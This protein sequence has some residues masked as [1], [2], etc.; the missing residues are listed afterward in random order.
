VLVFAGG[1]GSLSTSEVCVDV[2]RVLDDL[3]VVVVLWVVLCGVVVDRRV[4]VVERRVVLD[5]LK[6]EPFD[7]VVEVDRD[8]VDNVDD[9]EDEDDDEREDVVVDDMPWDDEP[10]PEAGGKAVPDTG[11][12]RVVEEVDVD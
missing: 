12:V 3:L 11:G 4:V 6:P 2:G 8:D 7:R 10:V 9:R 1:G 5:E